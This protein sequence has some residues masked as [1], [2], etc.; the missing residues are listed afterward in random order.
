MGLGARTKELCGHFATKLVVGMLVVSLPVMIVMAVVLTQKTSSSLEAE[1][2]VVMVVIGALLV[3]SF[4]VWFARRMARPIV[5]VS[6]AAG[7]LLSGHLDARVDVE[8]ATEIRRLC[9]AFNSMMEVGNEHVA[10]LF[11]AGQ[12]LNTSAAELSVSSEELAAT[13]T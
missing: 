1:V 12:Q 10:G 2:R 5:A 11:H 8:G 4:S 9:T 13:T 6:Q 7:R 3:I